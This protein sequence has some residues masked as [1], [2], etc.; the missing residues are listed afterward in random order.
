MSIVTRASVLGATVGVLALG[1]VAATAV[2]AAE[3]V[4]PGDVRALNASLASERAAY[5]AYADALATTVLTPPVSAVLARFQ[6]EHGAHRDALAAALTQAGQT[7]SADAGTVAPESFGAEGDVLAYAYALERAQAEAYVLTVGPYKNRDF[8]TLAASIL[9]VTTA[10][11]ALLAEAL[12]RGP[13]YP[14]AL[15]TA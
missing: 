7:P 12:R 6:S 10:R 3:R 8:A 9:G 1:R 4:D 13:A 2:S 11:V 15:V 14:T 5:K